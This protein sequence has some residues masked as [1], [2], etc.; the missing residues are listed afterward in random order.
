MRLAVFAAAL[1]LRAVAADAPLPAPAVHW[2]A[3]AQG[4]TA[5]ANSAGHWVR[6]LAVAL[7]G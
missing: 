5:W 7:C 6:A 2:A 1:L 3:A 4:A